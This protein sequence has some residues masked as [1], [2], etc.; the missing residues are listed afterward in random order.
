MPKVKISLDEAKKRLKKAKIKVINNHVYNIYICGHIY[1]LEDDPVRLT[2][3]KEKHM[4]NRS[5]P[6]CDC[7]ALIAKYK[8]CACGYEQVSYTVQ[9][10]EFCQNC[11]DERRTANKKT[12]KSPLYNKKLEDIKK[13]QTCVHSMKCLHFY[14]QKPYQA[15]PCKNCKDY[16][17]NT[18][19]KHDPLSYKG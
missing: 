1:D 7:S 13:R 9:P 10:S 17:F 8:K 11:T 14:S 6:I 15:I 3:Y 2:Y 5:C 19:G 12:G 18:G 16:K 4:M